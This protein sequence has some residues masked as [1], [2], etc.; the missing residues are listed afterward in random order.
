M[1][2]GLVDTLTLPNGVSYEQPTGLFIDNEFVKPSNSEENIEVTNNQIVSV[3]AA[4]EHDVD[5]A[6]RAAR[7]AFQGEW[8]QLS[9][10][11]RGDHLRK[12]ADL[13][14]RDKEL[15][16]AIDAWDNALT[17]DVD[18]TYNVFKYYAGFADKIFGKTIETDPNK[19]AYVRHEPLGVCAQIVPWNFPIMMLAWKVAPAICCGN[20]VVLK[21]AEQTPLSALYF[22]KLVQEAGLPKGVIN[23]ISGYGRVAGHALASHMDVDKI[24][25]TGSTATGRSIMRDASSNLKNITLECG[26]KSPSIVFADA[27][28]EQAI[29]WTHLGAL[30]NSGQVCT[31]TARIYVE[32]PIYDRFLDDFVKYSKEIGKVGPQFASD[33]FQG[34]QVSKTQRDNVQSY[35]EQ[36]K[37]SGARLMSTDLAVPEGDGYYISPVIFADVP[38]SASIITE[39]VFGPVTAI[40]PF[41]SEAEVIASANDTSYGLA[42]AVFTENITKGH[43]VAAKLQAGM[44]WINSSNDSHYGIPFVCVLTIQA[45]YEWETDAIDQGGY[46]SSG[47]GRELGPYAVDTYTQAKAIHVNL[48]NKL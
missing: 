28:V 48:G 38:P 35:I 21:S 47:I 18:E 37:T 15:L 42:A 29:K 19:L 36:G 9:A 2:S 25:F 20:T 1:A 5:I 10:T 46:K 4:S 8:S 17:G 22:G 34:P 32:R 7:K 40:S 30:Y 14:D 31:S 39:E 43:R 44:V 24:A 16:A 45:V 26:G 6:V 23:I 3:H 33:T 12:L 11:A 13:I 41:D 27:D